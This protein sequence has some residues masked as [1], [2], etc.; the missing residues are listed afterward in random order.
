MP[1]MQQRL[2]LIIVYVWATEYEAMELTDKILKDIDD[3]N[4]S[5]AVFMDLSK[6]FDTLDHDILT[7]NR[8]IMEYTA[9][10]YNGSQVISQTV[11]NT[12]K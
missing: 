8:L 10:H 4:I 2:N 11:A 6:A 7:K 12:L 1:Q 5:L 9:L 3:K